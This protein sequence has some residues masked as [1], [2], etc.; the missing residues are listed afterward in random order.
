MTGTPSFE[1]IA[2]TL[3]AVEYLAEIGGGDL[4]RAYAMIRRHENELAARFLA[5]MSRLPGWRVWGV[6]D[7]ARPDQRVA[8]FGLTHRSL[9]PEEAAKALGEQGFFVWNGNFYAIGL[10]E[11]LGLA[12]AGMLRV[13]FLHYNTAA[14]VERLLDALA[15]LD[16]AARG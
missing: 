4:A 1:A 5:G 9:R 11:A 7:P 12:P 3:A 10:I 15:T 14:E 2:G 16:R 8:T 6:T 13:G